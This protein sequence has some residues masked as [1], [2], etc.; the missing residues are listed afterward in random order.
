M[1]SGAPDDLKLIFNHAS[2]EEM[3]T[4]F[5]IECSVAEAIVQHRPYESEIDLL[6]RGVIP[7]RAFEQLCRRLRHPRE[8]HQA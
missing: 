6:E 3:T 5:G 1:P 7:K 2:L 8:D 4:M